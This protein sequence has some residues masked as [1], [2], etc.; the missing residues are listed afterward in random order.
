MIGS[1]NGASDGCY[2]TKW[3]RFGEA[4]NAEGVESDTVGRGCDEDETE[5][6]FLPEEVETET[7]LP[8][9]PTTQ[10][11][12]KCIFCDDDEPED[13]IYEHIAVEECVGFALILTPDDFPEGKN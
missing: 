2:A 8:V 10:A 13:E 12:Y 5:P 4:C 11:P 3:Y 9:E 1:Y 6:T 7:S